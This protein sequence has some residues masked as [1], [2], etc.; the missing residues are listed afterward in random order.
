VESPAKAKTI[1]HIWQR[2]RR[3]SLDGTYPYLPEEGA[4]R[5]HENKFEPTYEVTATKSKIVSEL[6]ARRKRLEGLSLPDPV[7]RG[8]DRVHLSDMADRRIRIS[9]ASRS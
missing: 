4:G 8:G 1:N 2:L 7:G 6:K 3:Q 9:S 5:R